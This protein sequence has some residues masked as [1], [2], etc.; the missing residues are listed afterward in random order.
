MQD[1][2]AAPSTAALLREWRSRFGIPQNITSDRGATFPSQLHA[3]PIILHET[4]AF[5]P[6]ANRMMEHCHGILKAVLMS[7]CND[8]S[9]FPHLPW[10]LLRLRITPKNAIG[11]LEI[12]M[13]YG[14]PLAFPAEFFLPATS[15]NLQHLYYPVSENLPPAIILTIPNKE[16]KSESPTCHNICLCVHRHLQATA[17]APIYGSIL[18]HPSNSENFT[19]TTLL[20]NV[21]GKKDWITLDNLKPKWL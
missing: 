7:Y 19:L 21:R 6:A 20:F 13:V 17:Y 8:S 3:F 14:D 2:T 9:W 1:A 11:V 4:T 16:A 5:N 12:E 10:T 18:C 15:N